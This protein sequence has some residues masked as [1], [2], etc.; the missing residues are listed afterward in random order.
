MLDRHATPRNA[1]TTTT[2]PALR[3]WPLQHSSSSRF[4][5]AEGSL[6]GLWTNQSSPVG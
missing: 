2:T 6:S 5:P 1:H 4:N 3:L